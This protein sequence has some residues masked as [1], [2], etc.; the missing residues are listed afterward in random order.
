MTPLAV[1][2]PNTWWRCA[3]GLQTTDATAKWMAWWLRSWSMLSRWQLTLQPALS[4]QWTCALLS[5]RCASNCTH[6]TDV[7]FVDDAS[8]RGFLCCKAVQISCIFELGDSA[9]SSA[10]VHCRCAQRLQQHRRVSACGGAPAQTTRG[11]M[12]STPSGRVP[13]SANSTL[14]VVTASARHNLMPCISSLLWSVPAR[15]HIS[16]TL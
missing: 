6:P 9:D 16:N 10:H 8:V 4:L 3:S 12:R 1:F 15:T 7:I 5:R 13:K 2:R 14:R 11:I